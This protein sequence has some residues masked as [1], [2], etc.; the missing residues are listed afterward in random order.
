MPTLNS[1]NLQN[2]NRCMEN[3][4]LNPQINHL[5]SPNKKLLG[6]F[7]EVPE[8]AIGPPSFFLSP[9][10]GHRSFPTQSVDSFESQVCTLR[11]RGFERLM[12]IAPPPQNPLSSKCDNV[13][14]PGGLSECLVSCD[15][16]KNQKGYP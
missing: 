14:P 11:R 4:K 10:L 5:R 9:D 15:P 3:D 7:F 16:S 6:T 2:L 1:S 8:S 13:S 12:P